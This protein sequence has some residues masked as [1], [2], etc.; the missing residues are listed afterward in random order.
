[1]AATPTGAAKLAARSNR[2]CAIKQKW[3]MAILML[4]GEAGGQQNWLP[5]NWANPWKEAPGDCWPK[6]KD[7][8]DCCEGDDEMT[9][10]W[11]KAFHFENRF[12]PSF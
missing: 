3:A 12:F 4:M 9:D 2:N 11:P 7:L 5:P 1:M 10:P 8:T 6:R